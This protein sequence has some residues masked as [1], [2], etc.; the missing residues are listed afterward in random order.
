MVAIHHEPRGFVGAVGINY[1]AHLNS[2][3]LSPDLDALIGHDPDRPAG[4]A[5]VSGHQRFTVIGFGFVDRIGINHGRQQIADIVIFLTVQADQ[6]VNRIGV[7]RR[8]ADFLF[9]LLGGSRLRLR[10]KSDE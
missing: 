9:A 5:R 8:F 10:Q 3:L 1:A 6:I 7:L 2:F 4:D